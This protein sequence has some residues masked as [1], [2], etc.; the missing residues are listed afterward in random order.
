MKKLWSLFKNENGNVL[1]LVSLSFIGLLTMAGLVIDGGTLYLTKTELQ[2][3]A[4]AS[5]L[6]GAQALTTDSE[7]NVQA[8]IDQILMKH[9]EADALDGVFINLND[10]VEIDLGKKVPLAFSKLFGIET[11][12]VTAHAAAQLGVMGKAKGAAPL[13]IPESVSLVYGEEYQLKVDSSDVDTGNFGILA[14]QGP[15]AKTYEYNLANG[16]QD[17]LQVGEIVD[18]QTGNIAGKTVSVINDLVQTCSSQDERDCPRIL[19]IPVYKPYSYDQNQMK[20]VEITGFAY[21]YITEP[22]SQ[23]D[24]SIKGIFLE[25]TGTGFDDPNA[26]NRG[27]YSIRLVK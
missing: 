26:V 21:F 11:V 16:Y 3:V 2:K 20:Q 23:N 4:N 24:T 27:A 1:V 12:N 15:G 5:A 7:S 14:L 18:T 6:S 17:P 19:L 9:D 25:R 13:G 8:I 10:K 22:M